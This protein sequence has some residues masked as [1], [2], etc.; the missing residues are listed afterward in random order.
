MFSRFVCGSLGV[1]LDPFFSLVET[2]R[3]PWVG[4]R[5]WT[6]KRLAE[7]STRTAPLD[8]SG[9][10]RRKSVL[11]SHTPHLAPASR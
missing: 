2:S 10:R 9:T 4:T 11:R 1:R 8:A 5:G 6:G 7:C 3:D